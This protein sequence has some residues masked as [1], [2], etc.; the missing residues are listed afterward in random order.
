M[1]PIAKCLVWL[2]GK[3]PSIKQVEEVEVTPPDFIDP[4]DPDFLTDE[5]YLYLSSD[6]DHLE[7]CLKAPSATAADRT[8]SEDC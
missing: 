5:L 4:D 8:P 6:P 3:C 1:G 7:R 2:L